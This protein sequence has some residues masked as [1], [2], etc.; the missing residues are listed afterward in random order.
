LPSGCLVR[1]HTQTTLTTCS[2]WPQLLR[3]TYTSY[4]GSLGTSHEEDD[5]MPLQ[6]TAAQEADKTYR[7]YQGNIDDLRLHNTAS[8]EP[9]RI[10]GYQGFTRTKLVFD[11]SQELE[12][13]DTAAKTHTS[14]QN[15]YGNTYHVDIASTAQGQLQHASLGSWF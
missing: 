15:N 10:A 9:S 6:A 2:S 1:T 12:A 14:Y 4:Q 11:H 5:P 13:S 3:K 7:G 8:S